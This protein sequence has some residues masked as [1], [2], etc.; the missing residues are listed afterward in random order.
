[1]IT[2]QCVKNWEQ[3]VA[4]VTKLIDLLS[5]WAMDEKTA[6]AGTGSL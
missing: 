6:P 4:Q 1:M 3:R 5:D 2:D